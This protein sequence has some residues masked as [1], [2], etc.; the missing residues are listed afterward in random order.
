MLLPGCKKLCTDFWGASDTLCDPLSAVARRLAT[1]SV[2][3]ASLAA[4]TTCHLIALDKNPG[5]RPI[6]I[7][8]VCWW[9]LFKA[10]LSIYN[11]K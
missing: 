6:G 10:I 9:L 1:E 11:S 8:E 7:D 5:V 3:P 4:F 2:D